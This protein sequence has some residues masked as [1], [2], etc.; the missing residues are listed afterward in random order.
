MKRAVVIA[1]DGVSNPATRLRILQFLPKLE[2]AGYSVASFYVPYSDG[3]TRPWS[4]RE[5][6]A[7]IRA[8]DV[9]FVQR[10]LFWWTLPIIRLAGRPF[11][12][13]VDDA[14]H[15]IRQSQFGAAVAPTTLKQRMVV[16]FRTIIRGSR[17]HS[18]RK[19]YFDSAL[20]HATAV[21]VGNDYLAEYARSLAARLLVLPTAV[22]VDDI[23]VRAH[24][25]TKPV[26]IGWI[27]VPSN[28]VHLR[29][30]ERV[31]ADIARRYGDRVELVIVS[32]RGLDDLPIATEFVPWTLAT[33][34]ESTMTFDIGIMP[35]ADDFFSRGK[36]SFKAIYCMAHGV[37]VV[38]SPVGMNVKLVQ[39]GVNGMLANDDDEWIASLGALI[40]D[41]ELRARLGREA[42]TTIESQYSADAVYE[43]LHRLLDDITR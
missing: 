26:R 43:Q 22:P 36:C 6:F 39:H 8:S 4:L 38:I 12:F 7:A 37:P 24:A 31:F 28:L 21:I 23:P 14:I 20:R 40:E 33:E 1:Y 29:M 42:R 15:F 5:L 13:D 19:R 35:L 41:H 2:S 9:V 25:P 17:F 34:S 3:I 10:A 27:G 18:S 11:V 30:L 16:A 32:N